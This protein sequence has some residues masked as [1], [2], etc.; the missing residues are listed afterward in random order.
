MNGGPVNIETAFQKLS[1]ISG[2]EGILFLSSQGEVLASRFVKAVSS[3]RADAGLAACLK[4]V[5]DF[6]RRVGSQGVAELTVR[7]GLRNLL[8][9]RSGRTGFLTV[10]V[11]Q[12]SMNLALA[13]L[14]MK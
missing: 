7:G 9:I 3:P 8:L 12:E 11:G 5:D 4:D 1:E 13:K 2:F 14:K 6:A 10:V